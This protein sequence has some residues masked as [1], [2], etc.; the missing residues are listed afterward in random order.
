MPAGSGVIM[1]KESACINLRIY[2]P[3]KHFVP[4]KPAGKVLLIVD[5]Q[6]SRCNEFQMPD[7]A[8]NHDIA[9]LCLPHHATTLERAF[10][11]LWKSIATKDVAIGLWLKTDKKYPVAIWSSFRDSL[12][13]SCKKCEC[14]FEIKD[15]WN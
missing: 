15:G 7:F 12:G 6:A 4:W 1:D 8:R 13:K 9:H 2:W 10:S 11:S 3:K 5:G 14:S